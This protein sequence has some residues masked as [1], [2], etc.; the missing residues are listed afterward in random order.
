MYIYQ[1]FMQR[2]IPM[3]PQDGKNQDTKFRHFTF[4]CIAFLQAMQINFI[5]LTFLNSSVH[6]TVICLSVLKME[7]HRSN[8]KPIHF[9]SLYFAYSASLEV[10]PRIFHFHCKSQTIHGAGKTS[11]S[12]VV[13]PLSVL[14]PLL[15]SAEV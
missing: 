9:I 10:K 6:P 14:L 3:Y 2:T 8:S 15:L 7:L 5:A 11:Q 1:Q 4:I 12:R 13:S